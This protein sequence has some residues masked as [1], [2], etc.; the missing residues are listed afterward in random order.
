MT[1]AT[2]EAAN[3]TE[4][5]SIYERDSTLYAFLAVPVLELIALVA[6]AFLPHRVGASLLTEVTVVLLLYLGLIDFLTLKVPNLIVYP[7]IAFVLIGTALVRMSALD[8]ALMGGGALLGIM[9]VLAIIGRGSMGMGD[10][11]FAC[12]MGCALGPVLGVMALASGFVVGAVSAIVLLVLHLK[13]RKDSVPL[14]PYLAVG[15]V[16]WIL[17]IGSLVTR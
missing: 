16:F 12:L 5:E 6:L 1:Y 14:T 17:F 10:V 15:G 13:G 7:S 3:I 8:S 4:R 9:F 2:T 11:K